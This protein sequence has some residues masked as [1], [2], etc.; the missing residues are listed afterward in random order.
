M[1]LALS[2]TL[3]AVGELA[4]RTGRHD[5]EPVNTPTILVVHGV[6]MSGT[7]MLGLLGPIADRLRAAGFELVAP[8]AGKEMNADNLAGLVEWLRSVYA[9]HGQDVD[10]AFCDGVFWDGTHHDWFDAETDRGTG[11]KHYRALE[12]SLESIRAATAGCHV[13][14]VLGF[15]QGCAMAALATG[16]AKRGQLP[17][18]DSLRFGIYLSGFKAEFQR[19]AVTAWPVPDVKGLFIT[20]SE[21]AI[22]PDPAGI[23]ALAAEFTE[24]E[25]HVVEGLTHTVPT[26]PEWVDRIVEFASRHG[27]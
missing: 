14:G 17:F 21:D 16:L 1:V 13:V 19:P 9:T 12:S 2:S 8:N 25:V 20:G 7:S 10:D 4:S 18:G 23:R 27:R 6:T 22:F 5:D 24:P 15:S 11:E 26:T 3:P